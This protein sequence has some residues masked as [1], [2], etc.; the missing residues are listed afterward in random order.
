MASGD[1]PDSSINAS[2]YQRHDKWDR[3][4]RYARLGGGRYWI[5]VGDDVD[6]D[7]WIQVDL[8]SN[9]L[10]TGVQT[11]GN[12]GGVDKWRYWVA[13]I[14]VQVGFTEGNLIFIDDSQGQPEVC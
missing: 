7:P 13:Q 11:E 6:S 4:P 10:V 3:E 5:S 1:I 2:S 8:G 9:H 12:D 14:K